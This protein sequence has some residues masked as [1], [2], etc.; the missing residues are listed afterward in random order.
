MGRHKKNIGDIVSTSPKE[1]EEGV[2]PERQETRPD[3]TLAQESPMQASDVRAKLEEVRQEGSE[4]K[5]EHTRKK[6]KRRA[7]KE[8]VEVAKVDY[9]E[10]I[11]AFGSFVEM[12]LDIVVPRLPNP[13]PLSDPERSLVMKQTSRLM[14][15]Y[16]PLLGGWDVEIAFG[17]AMLFVFLPRLKKQSVEIK[18]PEVSVAVEAEYKTEK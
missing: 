15:K 4:L 11:E 3:A 10:S 2:Q 8:E 18:S 12:L 5:E 14:E 17:G 6:Y 7:K 16:V 9:S 1:K 13:L